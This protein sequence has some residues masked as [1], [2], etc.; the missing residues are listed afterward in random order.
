MIPLP[1]VLTMI[2]TRFALRRALVVLAAA[3][4]LCPLAA[5]AQ[6]T[7]TAKWPEKPIRLLVAGPAGGSADILA[8]VLGDQLS[9][10]L[11][12]PVIVEPKPGAGGV[13]AVN[14][15]SQ[16]PRDGHTLLVAVNALVSEIPHIVKLKLDMA[17]EITPLAELG[18]GGLVLVGNPGVPAK[19]LP[20]L[21]NHVKANPGKVNYASYSAGTSSHVLGLQL[22]QAAGIDMVHVGYKGSTPAL[23]DLMGG[24]VPLMFDGIATSLPHLKA[25]KIKAFAI[26]LPKRSAL[27][28][29]VPTFSELGYAKMEAVAWMGLWSKPDV[30]AAVQAQ[31]RNAALKALAQ[32]AVRDRLAEVGF[33]P[34][35]PRS[36]EELSRGLKADFE[37]MGALLKAIDFKPE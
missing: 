25:G 34:G 12:Q 8:R 28:P 33:E 31:V 24:H 2:S 14:E 10:E 17:R 27:L 6:T 30:P 19:T 11:G 3:A 9:K 5:T 16:A 23:Q 1:G 21:L 22:N 37:R 32:P 26:S 4:A 20:E 18:R 15:L 35:Q 7:P 13:L 36:T 29:D